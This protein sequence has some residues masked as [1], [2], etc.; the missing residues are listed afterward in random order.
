MGGNTPIES[1]EEVKYLMF[2][3]IDQNIHD[4]ISAGT[5]TGDV[6]DYSYQPPFEVPSAAKSFFNNAAYARYDLLTYVSDSL[7][8]QVTSDTAYTITDRVYFVTTA[9]AD[10]WQTFTAPFDVENIYV[11]ETYDEATLAQ[12]GTRADI[13]RK[14]ASHNADFA[15]FF[16]VAMAM[17]TDKDFDGIYQSYRKWA[18]T[19]DTTS[20]LYTGTLADYDLRSM[21]ELIPYIGKNWRD[22]NF[23]LNH[24]DGNWGLTQYKDSFAVNWNVLTEADTLDGTLLHKGETYSLM[25]PY[26]PNCEE[27]GSLDSRTDWDYWSGK[28]LIFE[29]TAGAQVINGRD[30]LNDTISG[31]VF[32]QMVAENEVIVTGNSTFAQL[33]TNRD[34]VYSYNSYAPFMNSEVFEPLQFATDKIIYPTT[35]FLYGNVPTRNGAPARSIGRTGKIN[36]GK[37]NTPTGNP[38]GNIPTVGGGNDLFITSTVEGINIAVAEPQHVRVLSSTGAVLYSGMVQTAVDVALPTTGVYVITGEN[39]VHKILH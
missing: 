35:A 26:C 2:C 11:V 4:V 37:E 15:A 29:S 27:D 25:F 38:G 31:N 1:D 28:F 14:Q 16:A 23:Y 5:T 30:F 3:Q 33:Q 10:I 7:Q 13:L 6:V 21:Q 32:S 20:H 22:A 8:Y 18:F 39:E 34:N 36:Y 17:G 12:Q 24:N 9:T 19:Q